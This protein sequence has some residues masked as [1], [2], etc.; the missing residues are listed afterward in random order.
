MLGRLR[1]QLHH[2]AL[3]AGLLVMSLLM[4]RGYTTDSPTE[5]ELTHMVR[6]IAYWQAPDTRLSYGH[7]PLGNAWTSLPVAFDEGN[8]RIESLKG[9]K[10]A[11]AAATTKAYVD[12]DYG[13]ARAQ[14]MRSRLAAMALGLLL[15]AY[16]YYWCLAIFGF[17]T[18]LAA[19][20]L[21][22]LN[23][24]VIAQCRYVTTDPPAMLGYAIAVGELV[25]YLR[26]ARFSVVLMPLGLSLGLLTKYSGITLVPFALLAALVCCVLGLGRFANLPP[27]P[28]FLQLGLHAIIASVMILLAINVSYKFNDTGMTVGAILDKPEP[29]YWVS[30]R[31]PNLFERFTPLPKLPPALP[32]PLPYTYLFGIAGIRGHSTA[33]FS[34]FYWG[35]RLR[36]A[37]PSYFPVMLLIKNPP[38]LLAFL[39]AGAALAIRRRKLSLPS[40]TV[41][42][43]AAA[44]L[45]VASRSNLAMGVRHLLPIIPLLSILGA[46]TFDHLWSG[47]PKPALRWG[48]GLLLGTSAVSAF[49][50]GPDYLGYFNFLTGGRKGGHQISIYG[51][52]WG[53]DRQRLAE[54]VQQRKLEPLYYDPQTPMRAQEAKHLGLTYKSLRCGM[55]IEGAWVA[56]HALTY[57]TRDVARCYPYLEGRS[58][59]LDVND[60]IY[61]FWIPKT[62]T[63][64][65]DPQPGALTPEAKP[66]DKLEN[67]PEAADD[68]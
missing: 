20:V 66:Q 6:G 45:A 67:R 60:H 5:D 36:K 11:T 19:L 28:R 23:P 10:H 43:G 49:T 22:A 1:K 63:E 65:E 39:C 21:L 24:V 55:S 56:L 41:L 29:R 53:Q 9:W 68:G 42:A 37:P 58:P 40:V 52:D 8:P 27:K 62:K 51:E 26:G 14:L 2:V 54:L 64:H 25:R 34:S 17:R 30:S 12:K 3:A 46:R 16:V 32:V 33:G 15:V 18:A 44:F 59:D 7:P 61:L 47:F 38:S 13:Y 50:A 4:L 35:E 31:Y 57:R 48:L